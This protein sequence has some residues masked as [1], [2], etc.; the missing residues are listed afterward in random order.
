MSENKNVS[1][2]RERARKVQCEKSPG[3]RRVRTYGLSHLGKERKVH[4]PSKSLWK[5]WDIP[6]CTTWS[7]ETKSH[8]PCSSSSYIHFQLFSLGNLNSFNLLL[9]I[10]FSFSSII[11]IALSG[12]LPIVSTSCLSCQTQS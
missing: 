9:K 2:G 5:N 6:F 12:N 7:N 11:F 10:L 3:K 1:N 4:I 8:Q